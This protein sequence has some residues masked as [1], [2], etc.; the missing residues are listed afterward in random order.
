MHLSGCLGGNCVYL[1]VSPANWLS[2]RVSLDAD[3]FD[4]RELLA[5]RFCSAAKVRNGGP[6]RSGPDRR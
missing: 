1:T 6:H 2:A 4:H 3:L 5:A